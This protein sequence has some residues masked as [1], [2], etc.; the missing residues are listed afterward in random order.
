MAVIGTRGYICNELMTCSLYNCCFKPC[1]FAA[2]NS[3]C[4]CAAPTNFDFEAGNVC[5]NCIGLNVASLKIQAPHITDDD[6]LYWS[7]KNEFMDTP[8]LVVKDD[9]L[10]SIVIAVRVTLSFSDVL[11]DM[12]AKPVNLKKLLIENGKRKETSS[13]LE[14]ICTSN[15]LEMSKLNDM[16]ED[17]EVHCG[18]A[19]AAIDIFLQ[20]CF[21]E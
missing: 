2:S 15:N 16:P 6:I 5:N 14:E 9:N 21:S 19:V 8:F 4:C 13:S 3:F 17:I 12:A 11:T 20:V 7:K 10:K 18:M 1:I